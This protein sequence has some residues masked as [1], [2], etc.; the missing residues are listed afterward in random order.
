M[1]CISLHHPPCSHPHAQDPQ[2]AEGRAEAP[3]VLEERYE[4]LLL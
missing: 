3:Q 2:R 4:V 1:S